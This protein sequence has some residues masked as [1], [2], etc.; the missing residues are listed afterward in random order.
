MYN[1]EQAPYRV[2]KTRTDHFSRTS[3]Q[4]D[5]AATHC[6]VQPVSFQTPSKPLSFPPEHAVQYGVDHC[7][8]FE[9]H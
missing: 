7:M 1:I 5:S 9:W 3:H 4:P 6:G 2:I 8:C